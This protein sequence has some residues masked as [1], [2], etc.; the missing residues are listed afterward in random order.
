MMYTDLFPH[1]IAN[2]FVKLIVSKPLRPL[3]LKWY[4]LGAHCKYHGEICGHSIEDCCPFKD[5]VQRLIQAGVLS[6]TVEEQLILKK[7]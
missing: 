3:F 7:T 1:T 6:F 2:Q 5:E 4:N